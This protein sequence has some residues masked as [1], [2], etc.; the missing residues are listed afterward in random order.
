MGA[1]VTRW[2]ATAAAMAGRSHRRDAVGCQDRVVVRERGGVVAAVLADGA[3]SARFGQE[4]A[5]AATRASLEALLT[6]PDRWLADEAPA[7]LLVAAQDAVDARAAALCVDPHELACT[8]LF[9]C[10]DGRRVVCGQVGDGVLALR[11]GGEWEVPWPP[12]RGE[13]ANETVFVTSSSAERAMRWLVGPASDVDGFAV[14][15]D[16]AA[17]VLYLRAR[18]TLAPAVERVATWLEQAP[19]NEVDTAVVRSMGALFLQRTADDCSVAVVRRVS[20][21]AAELGARPVAFSKAFLQCGQTRSARTRLR[22]LAATEACCGGSPSHIAGVTG[23]STQ[24]V[25]RHLRG[26]K[27]L[28][29]PPTAPAIDDYALNG[30]RPS[31]PDETLDVRSMEGA[32]S[33]TA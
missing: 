6:D 17:E 24:T 8:L 12:A 15:S 10:T 1:G 11:R 27:L 5:D 33:T 4:G 2:L 32:A 19:E 28:G 25:R 18:Q 26:L 13:H 23:L 29:A 20:L 31:S 14:M 3:G 7:A 9:V 21:D 22:V 30:E 16:G